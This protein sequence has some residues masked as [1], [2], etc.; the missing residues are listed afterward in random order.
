MP[1]D[2]LLP[3]VADQREEPVV[4]IDD[5]A[6]HVEVDDGPFPVDRGDLRVFLK[7]QELLTGDVDGDLRHIAQPG[8]VV[9]A[10]AVGA[11][12]P[13]LGP[14]PAQRAA[15]DARRLALSEGRP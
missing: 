12:K 7:L 4:G 6:G 8:R 9:Q 10:R 5:R 14:V 3:R 13:Y 1:A 15:I 2:H 11:S